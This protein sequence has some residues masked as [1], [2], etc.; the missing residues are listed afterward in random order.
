MTAFTIL[1]VS[2]THLSRTHSYFQDN[3]DAFIDCVAEEQPDFVFVT[4]DMC[5]NGPVNPD[6]LAYARGQMDRL[7]VAWRAMISPMAL[8]PLP[9]AAR[10][11]WPSSTRPSL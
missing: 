5:F 10:A 1:Q 4:G 11:T 9:A 7:P 2:D 8:S 3:W 6:D